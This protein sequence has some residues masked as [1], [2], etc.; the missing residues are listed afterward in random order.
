MI[1]NINMVVKCF[2]ND[3]KELFVNIYNIMWMILNFGKNDWYI[4]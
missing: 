1:L 4:I 2:E 3:I